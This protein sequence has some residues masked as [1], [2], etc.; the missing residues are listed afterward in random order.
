MAVHAFVT[1]AGGTMTDLT[2]GIDSASAQGINDVGQVAGWRNYRAVRWQNGGFT[3]LGVPDGFWGSF[4]YAINDSGQVAGHVINGSGNVERIFRYTDGVGMVILGG[5]GEQNTAFG[6]N[7]AGDVVGWGR[8][9]LESLGLRGFLFTDAAGMVDLNTKID[10]ATGWVVLGASGINDAGQ[11][12]AWGTNN[13]TGARHALRLT[14]VTG[15]GDAT[16]PSVRFVNPTDGATV[17]GRVKVKIVATDNVALRRVALRVDG[18]LTAETTTSD[19]LVWTWKTRRFAAGQ[20]T[21]TAVA[22]DTSGNQ[23]SRSIIV[24]V[25]H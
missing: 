15:T 10:P 18:V 14:P 8:P 3:D 20:H 2:P 25:R 4:G 16:A 17:T 12:A 21:L 6:I 7:S 13:L 9:T 23:A 1:D 5:L 24:T 11:I 22:T 19:R